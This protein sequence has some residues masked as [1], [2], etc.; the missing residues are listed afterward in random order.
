MSILIKG[1]EMP[2]NCLWCDLNYDGYRCSITGDGTLSVDD[3]ERH[4][5]CPLIELP[6][7]GRL[8][9]ADAL[10]KDAENV[11]YKDCWHMTVTDS[12]VSV[13]NIVHAP[14]IIEAEVG[15]EEEM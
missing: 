9:D 1:M 4:P 8:I 11:S 15:N 3:N 10:M 14:T 7:H 13:E 12:F 5:N 6:P 2:K